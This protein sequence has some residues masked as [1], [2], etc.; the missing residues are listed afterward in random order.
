MIQTWP[1]ALDSRDCGV[2]THTGTVLLE[3]GKKNSP[4]SLYEALNMCLGYGG[5]E[6]EIQGDIV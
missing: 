6:M 5:G 3:E 2:Y 1:E 4:Q